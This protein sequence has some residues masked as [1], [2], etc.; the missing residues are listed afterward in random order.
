MATLD[1]T[2]YTR[3]AADAS[4]NTV[5]AGQ[6]PGTV[7][8]VAISASNAQSS[9]LAD[10]TRYVRLHTDTACRIAFGAT[11]TASATTQ[12]MAANST[13]FFGVTPGTRIA[14]IATT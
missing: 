10:S 11:P 3:L 13:E 1:I 4:G 2:E 12:R 7:Q 14:V 5:M 8:Q 9:P 6:E